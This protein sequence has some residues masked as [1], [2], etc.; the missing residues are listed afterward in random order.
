MVRATPP[1]DSVKVTFM[2]IR[3]GLMLSAPE[4]PLESSYILIPPLVMTLSAVSV[5]EALSLFCEFA[6]IKTSD[7]AS[8]VY[9]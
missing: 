1:L 3:Y 8:D 9:C 6:Y 4:A 5:V 2:R 7:V